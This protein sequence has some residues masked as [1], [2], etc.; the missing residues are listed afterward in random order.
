[1]K[2]CK[3]CKQEK[4]EEDF[5]KCSGSGNRSKSW[6]KK[7]TLKAAYLTRKKAKIDCLNAYG[8]KC[9]CCGEDKVEFLGIDHVE[10]GGNKHRKKIGNRV[11]FAV[12]KE[13]YP[14]K[15]RILC[16]NCNL[17]LGFFGYCPHNKLLTKKGKSNAN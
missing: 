13:G 14:D 3:T 4:S 2:V 7:C 12:R 5:Y 10:G 1:M 16:H 17:S 8:N 6:C 9:S 11:H 15:Y